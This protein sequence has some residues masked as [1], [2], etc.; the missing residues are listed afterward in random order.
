VAEVQPDFLVTACYKWLLGPYSLGFLYVA[1]R[2]QGSAPIEEGWASREG[3]EDFAGLTRYRDGYQP[4]ARRFDVGERSNFALIPVALAA[5]AQIAAW[6][7]DGIARSLGVI[8]AR[9]VDELAP[10]GLVAGDSKV[11]SQHLLGLALPK[12]APEDLLARLG[13]R[14][15]FVSRRGTRLRIAPHLHVNE[16][17]VDRLCGAVR[18]AMR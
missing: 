12:H 13:A 5:L 16:A 11:R 15:V 1:P 7:P 6:T 10:L 3:A 9:I 2:W 17:D 18:D 14:N 8:N 4:G